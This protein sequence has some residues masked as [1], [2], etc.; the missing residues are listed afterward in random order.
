MMVLLLDF[1]RYLKPQMNRNGFPARQPPNLGSFLFWCATDLQ[2]CSAK[3]WLFEGEQ[4]ETSPMK[5]C[6]LHSV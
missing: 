3:H 2:N 5:C 1:A 6:L 4:L